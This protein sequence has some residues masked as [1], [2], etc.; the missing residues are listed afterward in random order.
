M[1]IKS[2]SPLDAAFL[3]GESDHNLMNIAHLDFFRLPPDAGADFIQQF[4]DDLRVQTTAVTP[5]NRQL[6]STT[7][8]RVLPRWKTIK[9]LDLD[10]HLQRHVLPQPGEQR[11]LGVLVSRLHGMRMNRS[12]PLW[13]IHLIEGMSDGRIA[14]YIKGHHALLDGIATIRLACK[15]MSN[16]PNERN[17]PA[18][19]AY[20]ETKRVRSTAKT[21]EPADA[22][23]EDSTNM[24]MRSILASVQR[25]NAQVSG[26]QAVWRMYGGMVESTVRAIVPSLPQAESDLATPFSA[27]RSI[28][29]GPITADRKIATQSFEMSRIEALAKCTGGTVNDV[30]LAICAGG[31]R[32]Y[33]SEIGELPE[34][35]LIAGMPMSFRPKD[36]EDIEGNA[37]SMGLATLATD[38]HDV[39]ERFTAIMASTVSAKAH[40][41]KISGNAVMTYTAMLMAP[42]GAGLVTGA[43]SRLTPMFNLVISNLPGPRTPLYYNGMTLEEWH[44]V[45]IPL[46]GQALN[47]TIL[48][49]AERLNL[50]ITA[51]ATLPHVQ[52]LAPYCGEALSELEHA[53]SALLESA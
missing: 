25:V 23:S 32:R 44:A 11:D 36:S 20:P 8:S 50:C 12:R 19:W 41:G 53:F 52:R 35:S 47:I 43:S 40:M 4:W 6:E 31:L 48:S 51:S 28:L 34:K 3:W 1:T 21:A 16:D 37:V 10:Y 18:I 38:I 27:P 15:V 14:L 17:R 45:S 42:F 39:R 46:D 26:I 22:I 30:I 49:Y 9:T 5:F 24:L 7:F 29:N 2:L 13:Q 33:L